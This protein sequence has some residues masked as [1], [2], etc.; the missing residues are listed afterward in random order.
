MDMYNAM[1]LRNWKIHNKLTTTST[2]KYEPIT[3][4]PAS[5]TSEGEKKPSIKLNITITILFFSLLKS[6]LK[7]INRTMLP[8]DLLKRE[9]TVSPAFWNLLQAN[10][11]KNFFVWFVTKQKSS[12]IRNFSIVSDWKVF[13]SIGFEKKPDW[14]VLF[15]WKMYFK[16]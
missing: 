15:V 1:M 12:S 6:Q 2:M 11:T 3:S 4:S 16:I 7:N 5:N 10:F 13:F 8:H 14:K 9:K